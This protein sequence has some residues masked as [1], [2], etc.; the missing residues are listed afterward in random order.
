MATTQVFLPIKLHGQKGYS[1][2]IAKK[3][4]MTDQLTLHF[5]KCTKLVLIF[6]SQPCRDRTFSSNLANTDI[7]YSL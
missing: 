1:P 5:L 2:W 4:G 3:L 7:I 6:I